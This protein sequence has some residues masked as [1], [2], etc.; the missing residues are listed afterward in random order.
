VIVAVQSDVYGLALRFLW[1]PQ[2]AEDAT[3]EILIRVITG[4]GNFRGDSVFRT[5]VYRIACIKLL[6]LRKY[7]NNELKNAQ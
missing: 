1:H 3:Q 7:V 6:T 5:W 2:D 4:L